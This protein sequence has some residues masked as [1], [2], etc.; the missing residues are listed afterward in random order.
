MTVLSIKG[1]V[2]ELLSGVDIEGNNII[3]IISRKSLDGLRVLAKVVKGE[4]Y[5][6]SKE[7]SRS[8]K[9]GNIP[10]AEG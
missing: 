5:D 9:K 6:L 10:F 4:N 7:L 8:N 3:H 2:G 1:D